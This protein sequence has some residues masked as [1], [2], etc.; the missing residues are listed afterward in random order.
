MAVIILALLAI[1]QPFQIFVQTVEQIQLLIEPLLD[2]LVCAMLVIIML[3]G[4]RTV[5]H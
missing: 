2:L 4:I 1:L 5:Q 3:L